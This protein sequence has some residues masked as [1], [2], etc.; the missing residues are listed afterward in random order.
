MQNNAALGGSRFNELGSQA[1][2]K[3]AFRFG[4][5]ANE[6]A[7]VFRHVEVAGLGRTA[8]QDVIRTDLKTAG[9]KIIPGQPSNAEIQIGGGN[10]IHTA[11]KRPNGV[12]N[13]GR[14]TVK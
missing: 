10:A 4:K 2:E 8:G 13:V 3:A 1:S 5:D 9:S 12:L 14:I 6:I 7:H 11:F